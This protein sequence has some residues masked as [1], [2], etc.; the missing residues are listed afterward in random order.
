M[1]RRQQGYF[2]RQTALLLV[3][4]GLVLAFALPKLGEFSDKSKVAEAYH[5]AVES[6][7]RLSEFYTLSARFPATETEIRAVTAAV[8]RQP[9]FVS[10]I[11]VDS[12]D[13]EH[14]VVVRIFLDKDLV[15]DN[16]ID[17]PYIY[18]AGNRSSN[19]G[20]GLKW[21]CGAIGVDEH[22]LPASCTV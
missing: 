10:S 17:A 13:H 5:I 12:D 2:S 6:K 1:N 9:E 22:L 21:S 3:L 16:G 11:V 8:F 15:G 14:D 18:V 19:P 7:L 4:F 20:L